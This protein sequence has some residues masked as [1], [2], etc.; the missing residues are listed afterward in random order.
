MVFECQK[1]KN[2]QFHLLLKIRCPW[3]SFARTN[4]GKTT[5]SILRERNHWKEAYFFVKMLQSYAF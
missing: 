2:V 3:D 5:Y 4:K 1:I